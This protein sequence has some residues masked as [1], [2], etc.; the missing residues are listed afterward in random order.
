MRDFIYKDPSFAEISKQIKKMRMELRS[1]EKKAS[2]RVAKLLSERF[3]FAISTSK[4][5]I[6]S[7]E[8]CYQ[9]HPYSE[10]VLYEICL[11]R[12]NT[13]K[14]AVVNPGNPGRLLTPTAFPNSIA[15]ANAARAFSKRQKKGKIIS[16]I[17][18]EIKSYNDLAFF[19]ERWDIS[20]IK[21]G[22]CIINFRIDS[23]RIS[24]YVGMEEVFQIMKD[25]EIPLDLSYH[26]QDL[27]NSERELELKRALVKDLSSKML[28]PV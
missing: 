4:W 16:H 14:P 10:G 13:E 11:L 21:R 6:L 20:Q 1:A 9:R 17:P 24:S 26:I 2:N 28:F 25:L 18:K 23:L 19:G 12:V 22:K 5:R 27:E 3:K 8:E 15:S 7:K